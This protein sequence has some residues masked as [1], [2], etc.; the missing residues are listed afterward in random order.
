MMANNKDVPEFVY[1]QVNVPHWVDHPPKFVLIIMEE[2][3]CVVNVRDSH[4]LLQDN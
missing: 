1:I 4:G 3:Q 2:I